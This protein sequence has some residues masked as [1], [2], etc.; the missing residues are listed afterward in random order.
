MCSLNCV[1]E[2]TEADEVNVKQLLSLEMP[3]KGN[4]D[5][6]DVED[7]KKKKKKQHFEGQVLSWQNH[8]LSSVADPRHAPIQMCFQEH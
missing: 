1:M 2:N 8:C 5:N 3:G 7:L 6:C 4:E